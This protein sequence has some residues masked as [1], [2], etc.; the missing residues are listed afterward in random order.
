MFLCVMSHKLGCVSPPHLHTGAHACALTHIKT[1]VSWRANV[2]SSWFHFPP[3]LLPGGSVKN[4]QEFK[5]A[6]IPRIL[7]R[8]LMLLAIQEE[9][10]L[11]VSAVPKCCCWLHTGSEGLHII[12][13][14]MVMKLYTGEAIWRWNWQ[15]SAQSYTPLHTILWSTGW[16]PSVDTLKISAR[17]QWLGTSLRKPTEGHEGARLNLEEW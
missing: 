11:Q 16:L 5:T 9:M 14:T 13:S 7:E 2:M 1:W 17:L 6:S 4:N 15:S 8:R 10:W 12:D 3:E